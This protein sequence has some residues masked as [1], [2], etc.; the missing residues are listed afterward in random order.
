MAL[1]VK[2][3]KQAKDTIEH[4]SNL[5]INEIEE[6]ITYAAD[7]Y[8]NTKNSVIS[9]E[10]YDIMIDFLKLKAPKSSV[11]K[12]IGSK[13][14]SKNKVKTGYHLG[15]MDKIKPTQ[16]SQL[17]NWM[18]KYP[19]PY[20]LS[21]KL[22]G[23][24]AL[25]VY[26]NNTISMITRGTAVE[27]TDISNLIKYLNI[28]SYEMV[29][30]YCLKNKIK[31]EDNMIAFRGEL[32]IAEKIFQ[33]KFSDK[34]KNGRN[35]VAG[36][37]NS[38]TINPELAS[39]TDLVLYEVVDP[40]VPIE[41][42]FD[43]IKDIGFNMVH[44]ININKELTFEYLSNY[45]KTRRMKSEY[46]IDGIIV[47]S[48]ENNER[49]ESG[50]PEYAFAFKDILEDQMAKTTVTSIEWNISKDGYIK[51][52]LILK[53]VTVGGVMIQRATGNNA[54]FIVDNVLG[55]GAAI[56]L[57]RSGDVI[58]KVTKVTKVATSGKPQLPSG[59]WHWNETNV[60]IIV[61]DMDNNDMLIKNLYYFF[62]KLDTKGLG[63]ANISKLVAAGYDSIKK[64]LEADVDDFME[65]DGFGEK[66]AENLIRSIKD[67]TSDVSMAM[68]M[69]ASNKLGHGIG[70]ERIKQVLSVY[71]NLMG[72][73][74]KWTKKE[75]INNLIEINGWEEKTSTLFVNNFGDFVKFYDS[76]KKYITIK[77]ENKKTKK[78]EFTN[79]TV[80]FSSFR[81]NNLKEQIEAMGGKVSTSVSKN[82][83]Y[84]IIKDSS[85]LD[86]PGEKIKKA[87]ELGIK[88]LTKDKVIKML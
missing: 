38:K 22:D 80:V 61:D 85:A 45:L 50:N 8:Y 81:D 53:P 5:D 24:S 59:K 7:K 21:D 16:L 83:N 10:I 33:E 84:V 67:A 40:F 48:C 17:T 58:P 30:K 27:G 82:T 31:G 3:L 15:S 75:F 55:P 14:K 69:A 56:E 86:E 60:D 44:N 4:I 47:T 23:I 19:P 62:S 42:Q 26:N 12:T 76:I 66:T 79:M 32:L 6:I 68:L 88:I 52:T 35:S 34:L 13:V 29:E 41:E 9:D 73:Y 87:L 25:V 70:I 71:P 39:A 63:E 74:K 28:P 77:T 78:G 54:K 65:V 2:Q 49:N 51:P 37:V 57:I 72:D 64:I 11:L 1:L 36:L 43:I 20:N 18:K 46:N